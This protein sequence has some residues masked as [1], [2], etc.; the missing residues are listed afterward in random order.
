MN[1]VKPVTT[2]T[3]AILSEALLMQGTCNDHPEREYGQVA[4]SAEQLSELK[5]WSGLT[6]N[7]EQSQLARRFGTNDPERTE[8]EWAYNIKIRGTQWDVS[9]G[10][11]NPTDAN[12]ATTTNWDQIDTSDK[13]LAGVLLVVKGA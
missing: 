13:T 1:S 6:G 4:G 10:G 7:R 8:S 9:S 2:K 11:A 3:T 5:I 12:L